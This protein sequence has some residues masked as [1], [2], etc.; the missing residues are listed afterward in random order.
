MKELQFFGIGGALNHNFAPNCAALINK[1]NF[2]IIDPNVH[3]I[4]K[5]I[6]NEILSEQT[7]EIIIIITHT[8][9]DHI[10]GLGALIWQCGII[11]KKTPIILANSKKF[12]KHIEKLLTM[13]GIDKQYYTF[14]QKNNITFND[15]NIQARKTIHTPDLDC[16]GIEFQDANGKYY[17]SG[18]TKELEYIKTIGNNDDYKDVYVEVSNYPK[19]HLDYEI[20]KNFTGAKKFIAMHFESLQLYEQVKKEK[21]LK[22]PKEFD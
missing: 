9:A 14:S 6:K 20:V 2:V 11:Y 7:T 19:S 22:L 3:C 16:F 21:L 12:K 10:S 5:L 1:H 15:I 17:Y 13:M 18:D 8:H 4:G